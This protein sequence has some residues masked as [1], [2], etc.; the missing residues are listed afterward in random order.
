MKS[1]HWNWVLVAALTA[2][3]SSAG[4]AAQ[5]TEE[6]D[7]RSI[8]DPR[9]QHRSYVFEPT[10]ER[11]PYALF[12]PSKYDGGTAWPLMVS[13]H[14]LTRTYDWLM[15]YEGF[16][17]M[18]E[19]DGYIIVTPLGYTRRGWFG[20]REMGDIGAY[21]EQDVMAV[22]ALV[23]EEFTIDNDRIYLW[24]H[25]MGGA[26]TYRLAT[27][28]PDIWA[29]L[30][31]AAPAPYGEP[32]VLAA[33]KHLP[34]IALQGDKDGLVTPTRKWVAHMK[35]LGMEHVYVEIAGG[36]HSL[37]I[38]KNKD[39]LSKLFSFFNIVSKRHTRQVKE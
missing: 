24:G 39:T 36:D 6:D 25:S 3:W 26:G 21:S 32:D 18:A 5:R 29:G 11:L 13:L 16:L 20:S 30:G 9:V 27:E 33:A 8:D 10:G 1:A 28:Y 19:R 22:L 31:V 7:A 15:G 4:A 23:R 35:K 37:F 12:V 14:G 2:V 34:I 38:S 17:D